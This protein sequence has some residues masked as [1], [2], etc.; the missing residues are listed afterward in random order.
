MS[1]PHGSEGGGRFNVTET[2]GL[3]GNPLL[4]VGAPLAAAVLSAVA[5]FV[6]GRYDETA[7]RLGLEIFGTA[8]AVAAV[9]R[10]PALRTFLCGAA[11]AGF[12]V[13]GLQTLD[14]MGPIAWLAAALA[15]AAIVDAAHV[16]DQSGTKLGVP[17]MAGAAAGL[18][19]QSLALLVL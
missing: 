16:A 11:A 13:I 8:V 2:L 17:P 4:R 18:A 1:A 5:F 19:L 7:L 14:T 12:F 15:V 9:L 3:T 6:H 10:P